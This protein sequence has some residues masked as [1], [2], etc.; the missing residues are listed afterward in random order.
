MLNP[1]DAYVLLRRHLLQSSRFSGM[2]TY[3]LANDERSAK[4]LAAISPQSK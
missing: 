1:L 3:E 4:Y 2:F